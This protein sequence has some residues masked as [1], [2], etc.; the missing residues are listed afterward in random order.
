MTAPIS[1]ITVYSNASVLGSTLVTVGTFPVDNSSQRSATLRGENC[2]KICFKAG[3][4]IAIP[5]FSFIEYDG[6]LFF[7]KETYRP[8]PKGNSYYEYN[9]KFVSF[10][11]MLSKPQAYRKVVV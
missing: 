9:M 1:Q 3:Q 11:N 7:L 8:V 5:A 6:Q 2:V 10:D 4:S